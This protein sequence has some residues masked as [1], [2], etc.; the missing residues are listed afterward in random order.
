MSTYTFN[1]RVD[2]DIMGPLLHKAAR[3]LMTPIP[4]NPLDHPPESFSDSGVVEAWMGTVREYQSIVSRLEAD[5][6]D[7]QTILDALYDAEV[8]G[9]ALREKNKAAAKDRFEAAVAAGVERTLK[10]ATPV[11]TVTKKA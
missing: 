1:L 7:G 11:P 9:I 8:D 10:A 2:P 4:P 5:N 6:T 3:S